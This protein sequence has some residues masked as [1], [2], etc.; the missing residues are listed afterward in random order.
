MNDFQNKNS[1]LKAMMTTFSN[2]D[3]PFNR[4]SN[5]LNEIALSINSTVYEYLRSNLAIDAI[6]ESF[7]RLTLGIAPM[8]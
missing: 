5:R 8:V 6:T 7:G 2:I 3:F 1:G 4:M